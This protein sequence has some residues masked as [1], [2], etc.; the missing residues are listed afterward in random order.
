MKFLR[1]FITMVLAACMILTVSGI[2][3]LAANSSETATVTVTGLDENASITLY[4]IADAT[5][6]DAGDTFTGYSY[7]QGTAFANEAEPTSQEINDIAA[8]IQKNG[9]VAIDPIVAS[10]PP[11]LAAFVA[12]NPC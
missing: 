1:K 12:F 4:K 3:A 2:A 6:N 8:G 11:L 7:L 5:Y 10:I 9:L